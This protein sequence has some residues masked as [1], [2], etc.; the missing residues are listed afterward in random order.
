M[1]FATS[2][3][4]RVEL[5]ITTFTEDQEA[6]AV[7]R[8]DGATGA[9]QRY[10]RQT[11]EL[12]EDDSVSLVGSWSA[13]LVLPEWPVTE[14][15]SVV[16]DGDTLTA[17]TDY[18]FDGQH[19]LWRGSTAFS[20]DDWSWRYPP[21]RGYDSHWG[22][23]ET[24]ITVVYSHGFDP[25]PPEVVEICV[26]AALRGWDT[27]TGATQRQ[28]GSWSASYGAAGVGGAV[29]LTREERRILNELRRRWVA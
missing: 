1:A 10:C 27:P 8:I 3:D 7:R 16:I 12:V 17:D 19:T 23:P 29:T 18:V 24:Q 13:G 6:R 11:I 28:I 5:G 9:I 22:G 2:D 15:T 14:V 25:V 21:P 26:S 4:L 20:W